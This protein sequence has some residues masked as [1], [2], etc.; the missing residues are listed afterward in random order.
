MLE[1]LDQLD[2]SLF[3][4]INR[5]FVHPWADRFFPAITDLH[6]HFY[7]QWIFVPWLAVLFLRLFSWKGIGLFLGL[8][9]AMASND[10]LGGQ[11]LKKS[12][13]RLRPSVAVE[14]AVIRSPDHGG[15]S[16]PSNHASNSATMAVYCALFIPQ[17]RWIFL[18]MAFLVGYSRVYGGVHY[19][20]DV[21]TGFIV[22]TLIANLWAFI[23]K[24]VL[25][26]PLRRAW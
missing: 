23:A 21:L 4:F 22:G 26:L 12:A 13:Q 10:F 9:L 6:Q 11:V 8:V 16:F 5:D 19:P 2:R 3:L 18:A 7:F 14:S 20:F 25:R 15:F 1:W 24:L 17:G